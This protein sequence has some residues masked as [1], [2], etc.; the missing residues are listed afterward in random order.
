MDQSQLRTLD[1]SRGFL[2]GGI[3]I[4]MVYPKGAGC[5]LG[6]TAIRTTLRQR[7]LRDTKVASVSAMLTALRFF[8]TEVNVMK[9][10]TVQQDPSLRAALRSGTSPAKDGGRCGAAASREDARFSLRNAKPLATAIN[11]N[12]RLKSGRRDVC[13]LPDFPELKQSV[14]QEA[15]AKIRKLIHRDHPILAEIKTRSQ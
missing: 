6:E 13:I 4:W 10:V 11:T 14:M 8:K 5:S 7:G 9:S 2:D 3:P 12:A 1:D 15:S